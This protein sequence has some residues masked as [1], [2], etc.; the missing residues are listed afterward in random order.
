MKKQ[1][2]EEVFDML[3]GFL[4]KCVSHVKDA[5]HARDCIVCDQE[6][7]IHYDDYKCLYTEDCTGCRFCKL[8][9]IQVV[10]CENPGCLLHLKEKKEK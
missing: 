5:F 6:D 7:S 10:R 1:A 9:T 3:Y 8:G 4:S 2:Y